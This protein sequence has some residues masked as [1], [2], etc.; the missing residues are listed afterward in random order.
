M[1]HILIIDDEEIAR[2]TLREILE[3]ENHRVTEAADG[4][5]AGKIFRRESFD[6]VITDIIM[7]DKEG[8]ETIREFKQFRPETPII[9]IS[10]GGRFRTDAYLKF[11]EE[12][13]ADHTL[14]KP[15]TDDDLLALVKTCLGGS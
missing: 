15:F 11:A 5:E 3:S 9:A 10:G 13:G 12:L 2:Y 8:L 6:L 7:P 1:A 14:N 4:V